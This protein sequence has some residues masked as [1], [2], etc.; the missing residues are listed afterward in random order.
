MICQQNRLESQPRL[1]RQASEQRSPL[2]H[3][4][5]DLLGQGHIALIMLGT[6]TYRLRLTRQ[7]KLILNK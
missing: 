4:A 3:D 5:T 1:D 6:A 2:V 7:G